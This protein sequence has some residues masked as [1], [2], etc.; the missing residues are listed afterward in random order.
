MTKSQEIPTPSFKKVD[1]TFPIFSFVE[2]FWGKWNLAHEIWAC[3]N[4]NGGYFSFPKIPSHIVVALYVSFKEFQ[5]LFDLKPQIEVLCFVCPP[6]QRTIFFHTNFTC[7]KNIK[8]LEME[9]GNEAKKV[10]IQKVHQLKIRARRE[11]IA[12]STSL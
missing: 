1:D 7:L 9:A 6:I 4:V 10:L 5:F 8:S 3:F 12:P 2:V 11:E